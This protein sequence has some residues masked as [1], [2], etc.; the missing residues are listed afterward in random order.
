[1]NLF[2]IGP[3]GCGKSTQAKLIAIKYQLVHL[4]TGKLFR[5][6]I[7]AQSSLGLKAEKYVDKGIWV[8]DNL[9]LST[10]FASLKKI[11]YQNF[12]ID[13]T[14]RYV[15][16]C[17]PIKDYLNKNHQQITALIH[18]FLSNKEI[19]RRRA[20]AGKKFQDSHRDDNSPQAI[21]HRQK[22]YQKTIKPILNFFRKQGN[23]I[24]IKGNRPV[25]PI[26]Q[27]ICRHIDKLIIN[28]KNT[29]AIRETT[30]C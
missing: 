27:E 3:S 16:Q 2:I 20:K 29:N 5:A 4:S 24:E 15:S 18:L 23:L 21:A 10:I 22:E 13:G 25:K 17:Q 6:E 14:P 28:Q 19:T 30:H 12:I 1:M 8:P 26:F 7:T 11:H 9:V